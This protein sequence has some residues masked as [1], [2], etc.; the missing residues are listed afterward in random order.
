MNPDQFVP[1]F[2]LIVA[3]IVLSLA[4][5][6]AIRKQLG[7]TWLKQHQEVARPFQHILKQ[8]YLESPMTVT[9]RHYEQTVHCCR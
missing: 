1:G 2:S 8:M 4:G 9:K 3:F 7:L 6:L 5:M